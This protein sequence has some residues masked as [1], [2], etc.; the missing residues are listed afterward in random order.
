MSGYASLV[1]LH[2]INLPIKLPGYMQRKNIEVPRFVDL[3]Q[4]I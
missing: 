4:W 1:H 2:F 3:E